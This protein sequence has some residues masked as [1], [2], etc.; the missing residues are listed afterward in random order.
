VSQVQ[1]GMQGMPEEEL[2]Q[3]N[4]LRLAPST[5][6]LH[7]LYTSRHAGGKPETMET[8]PL[9]PEAPVVAGLIT[10]RAWFSRS[11]FFRAI[12]AA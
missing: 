7:Q 6:L 11:P 2:V 9:K 5:W 10:K 1:L 8:K 12:I 3:R 4:S